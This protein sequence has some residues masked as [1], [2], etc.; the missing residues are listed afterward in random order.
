M[1]D[2]DFLGFLPHGATGVVAEASEGVSVR[3]HV[4][5]DRPPFWDHFRRSGLVYRV[6]LV[7]CVTGESLRRSR[8]WSCSSPY[9][10]ESRLFV[11][12]SSRFQD[13]ACLVW[14]TTMRGA[15]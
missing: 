7:D 5:S 6:S 15:D 2:G 13:G 12:A 8:W 9:L 11:V 3:E 4:T 10:S 1:T 14:D